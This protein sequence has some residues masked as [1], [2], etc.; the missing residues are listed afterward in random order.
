MV[1]NRWNDNFRIYDR[2]HKGI[3][4]LCT[5]VLSAYSSP[6]Q[7]LNNLGPEWRVI[8][9]LHDVQCTSSD[10]DHY[11]DHNDHDFC[12]VVYHDTLW[13]TRSS[14]STFILSCACA[15]P[16]SCAL[17]VSPISTTSSSQ[18]AATIGTC[19]PLH[20]S[21]SLMASSPTCPC[22][23]YQNLTPFPFLSCPTDLPPANYSIGFSSYALLANKFIPCFS[24]SVLS[25]YT[26]IP[27][28]HRGPCKLDFVYELA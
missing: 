4:S 27:T 28:R 10:R 7:G 16:L 26:Y 23:C 14:L 17:S 19:V 2:V 6:K 22:A 25:T 24:A 18:V 5:C 3:F 13:V 12:I 20:C 11:D 15:L 8:T 9:S 1:Q 21:P